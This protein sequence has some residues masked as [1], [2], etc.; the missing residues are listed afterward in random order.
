[1]VIIAKDENIEIERLTL[2][3]IAET[4]AYLLV[5]R[6]TDESILVDAPGE[7]DKI[8]ERVQ[9]RKLKYILMTHSHPDHTGALLELKLR[10][11]VPV[12]A[13]LLD[14]ADLPLYPDVMLN[15]GDSLS[16][17]NSQL[18]VLHTPGH[19]PGSLCFLTAKYLIAGDTIFPGGPGATRSPDELRQII[20]SLQEKIFTL[21]DDTLVFP[22]HGDSTV[23]KKEKE[24]FAVF[25]TK[26]HDPSLCG[27][28]LWLNSGA[29]D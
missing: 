11:D 1:M 6:R 29:G 18:K 5:C 27:N 14:A 26:P 15:D 8:L 22:G 16:F 9:G 12:A 24:E 21:P 10:L 20:E 2:F 7:A 13:H 28:V 17:G 25:G 19:T 3:G 23:L 4:N